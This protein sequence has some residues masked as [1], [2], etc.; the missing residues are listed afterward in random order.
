MKWLESILFAGLFSYLLVGCGGGGSGVANVSAAGIDGSYGLFFQSQN[1]LI[2]A[3]G[4]SPLQTAVVTLTDTGGTLSGTF[5][6]AFGTQ[7]VT[8]TYSATG[9][10][11]GMYLSIADG[12]QLFSSSVFYDKAGKLTVNGTFIGSPTLV[13]GTFHMAQN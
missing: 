13:N 6:N 1:P 11:P 9:V 2:G 7:N 3:G 12:T 8:G 4:A 10:N 5:Q